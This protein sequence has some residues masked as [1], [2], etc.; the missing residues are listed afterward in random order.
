MNTR[1]GENTLQGRYVQGVDTSMPALPASSV[2]KRITD[3]VLASVALVFLAPVMLVIA[4]VIKVTDPGPVFFSQVR[5]GAG[6]RTF[7][8]HKFRTMIVDA[9][10]VLEAYLAENPDA[11]DEWARDHK[12]RNDPRVTRIG[13]FLRKTSL[14][15]LPQLVNILRGEMSVVG[16]RPIVA[17]EVEKYGASFAAYS[18]TRP[19]LTGLWQVSGRNNTTYEERVALDK[20]YVDEWSYWKDISIIAATIPAVLLK[21][22]AF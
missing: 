11:A 21:K 16:P 15:E 1:T 18:A 14:D 13:A 6:G 19:G 2:A 3:V 8:C 17:E 5:Y 22:G 7:R 20:A 9:Q 4:L 10:Q 12:L